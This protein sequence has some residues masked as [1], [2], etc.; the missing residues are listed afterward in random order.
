[1]QVGRNFQH[2]L[3]D[4]SL[5]LGERLLHLVHRLVILVFLPLHLLH[6]LL[7]FLA[8]CLQLRELLL[9]LLHGVHQKLALLGFL[10]EL[11][12]IEH[13]LERLQPGHHA[14]FQ[15]DGLRGQVLIEPFGGHHHVVADFQ[16][17]GA[18]HHVRER[19]RERRISLR[20]LRGLVLARGEECGHVAADLVLRIHE[21]LADLRLALD[22]CARLLQRAGLVAQHRLE[23]CA[24][25]SDPAFDFRITCGGNRKCEVLQNLRLQRDRLGG[26]RA[27]LRVVRDGDGLQRIHRQHHLVHVEFLRRRR[28]ISE[29]LHGICQQVVHEHAHFLLRLRGLLPLRLDRR[30]HRVL[31]A[32]GVREVAL[33]Q[34]EHLLQIR[35]RLLFQ[36]AAPFREVA[37]HGRVENHVGREGLI[38]RLR[39]VVACDDAIG[40]VTPACRRGLAAP[41]LLEFARAPDLPAFHL[42]ALVLA[43]RVRS[44]FLDD[45]FGNA[46]VIRDMKR[47]LRT[48]ARRQDRAAIRRHDLNARRLV[49]L[50]RKLDLLLKR[51]AKFVLA[52]QHDRSA[53]RERRDS[54]PRHRLPT[55]SELRG[56][57][58]DAA[59]LDGFEW[60]IR[61]R[62]DAH[63]RSRRHRELALARVRRALREPHVRRRS[64]DKRHARE[65]RWRTRRNREP[66]GIRRIARAE[67][68]AQR[69]RHLRQPVAEILLQAA[70]DFA[71]GIH[72]L[73]RIARLDFHAHLVPFKTLHRRAQHERIALQH[74]ARAR[75][76]LH[77]FRETRRL[78]VCEWIHRAP[79][80]HRPRL[81]ENKQRQHQ[82]NGGD[83]QRD[84]VA[85][86]RLFIAHPRDVEALQIR[87]ARLHVGELER[88]AL[89][90][91]RELE[92]VDEM[93]VELRK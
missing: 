67:A 38:R 16:F 5:H 81:A 22:E 92:E 28:E 85:P 86:M 50:E 70:V 91:L 3:L 68:V 66:R 45:D 71:D 82:Q 8:Q 40:D 55:R 12:L 54:L 77:D 13:R 34:I 11:D 20:G 53:A 25:A 19:P 1:M 58:P 35:Q 30:L 80:R 32:R 17:P 63:D 21:L 90:I 23:Q 31:E 75:L 37:R 24:E 93:I 64:D 65:R 6:G 62:H 7:H 61:R 2:R 87:P 88:I 27:F 44:H 41:R 72:D 46:V 74:R 26:E 15:S 60:R 49:R 73:L 47:D 89:G 42:G 56:L 29:R 52:A 78:H 9:G 33:L 79:Q 76:H 4:I 39:P 43:R 69:R 14:V 59:C 36:I 83:G 51:A 84:P 48:L 10:L 57:I 18:R